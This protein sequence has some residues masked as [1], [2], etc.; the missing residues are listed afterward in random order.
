MIELKYK[1]YTGIKNKKQKK[2]YE[3]FDIDMGTIDF[4]TMTLTKGK[5]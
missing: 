1:G 4:E 2:E 3:K 5:V